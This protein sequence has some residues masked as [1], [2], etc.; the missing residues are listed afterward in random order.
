MDNSKL[1]RKTSLYYDKLSKESKAEEKSEKLRLLYVGCTRA[2]ERLF[3]SYAPIIYSNT[4]Y[5]K[6]IERKV[7]IVDRLRNIYL[8]QGDSLENVV[9][10]LKRCLIG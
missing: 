1:M 7:G 4:T 8:K 3:V 5:E 2:K 6:V 10:T 9:A